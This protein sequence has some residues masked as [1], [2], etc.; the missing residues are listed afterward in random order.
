MVNVNTED[1][2]GDSWVATPHVLL[3]V[4]RLEIDESLHLSLLLTF[5]S[6]IDL[7]FYL[8]SLKPIK[9]IFKA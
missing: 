6:E 5:G 3:L 2:H 9:N 4:F 1:D 8:I 7:Q